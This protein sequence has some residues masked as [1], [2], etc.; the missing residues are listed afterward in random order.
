MP[1]TSAPPAPMTLQTMVY[2]TAL[3]LMLGWFLYMGSGVLVPMVLG[4]MAA[5]LVLGVSSLIGRIP[6]LR[7]WVSP[8]WRHVASAL[9]NFTLNGARTDVSANA[10]WAIDTRARAAC[11]IWYCCAA[12]FFA[13]SYCWRAASACVRRWSYSD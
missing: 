10:L 9:L 12:P 8:G 7:R 1:E 3:A 6:G 4:L 5:Y 13:A 2:A 11:S